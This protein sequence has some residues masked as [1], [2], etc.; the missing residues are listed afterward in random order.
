[1]TCE[2]TPTHVTAVAEIGKAIHPMMAI[3]Q[4]EGGTAQ[5]LGYALTRRSGDEGR[6]HGEC[7][8]D[9]LHHPDAA[10]CARRWTS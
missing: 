4:I 5:G 7:H 2:V 8:A 6:P 3:G 1:M 10:G 9:Q